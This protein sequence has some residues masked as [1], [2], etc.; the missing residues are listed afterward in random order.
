VVLDATAVG[1]DLAER[2]PTVTAAC[3]E[4]GID[5]LTTPIPIAPTEHFLCGGI[6][7][8]GWGATDVVGL[9]AVGESA[10]TGVH[11]ANRLASNSLV[12]GMVFGR[13]L[14]SRLVL[15]LPAP[16]AGRI[17]DVAA[18]TVPIGALPAIRELMSAH[19]GIRR[20]GAGLELAGKELDALVGPQPGA[21]AGDQWLAANAIV[22]AAAERAE[23]RGCH[24][25]S[26]HPATNEW[27]RRRV[28][29][30]LDQTGLPI[31]SAMTPLGRT[32]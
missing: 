18:P 7:T 25:R 19:A 32:A 27:W 2:F 30:R 4:H 16:A 12:E 29:V 1:P 11:G 6:R 21:G 22:A 20:T 31:A 15:E 5:P 9:Y 10:A 14:A 26:D 3:R 13:R 24:W 17:V 23:S 8:D 28:V